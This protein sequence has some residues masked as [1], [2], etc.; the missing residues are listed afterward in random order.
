MFKNFFRFN[1]FLLL[2]S[3]G[4]LTFCFNSPQN[5][6]ERMQTIMISVGNTLSYLSYSP[7]PINEAYSIDVYK[8]YMEI[9][10]PMKRYFLQTDINE[11]EKSKT[12][13]GDYLK[14]GNTSFYNLTVDR[15]YQRMDEIE[16][17][18]LEILDQPI[19][20]N[21]DEEFILEPK[22]KSYPANK[23]EQYSDWKKYIKYNILQ[24][25]Q[26]MIDKEESQK[27][28]KDSVIANH[29]VDTIKYEPISIDEKKIKATEEVKSLMKNMFRRFKKRD[30]NKFFDVYMNAY[31][32]VFDP[33]SNYYSPDDKD[34]FDANFSG[35]FTGIGAQISEKTG[36]LY[37]G[38]LV[39]GAPAWKSK[40]IEEGDEV[41]K[42]KPSPKDE[43]INV[44]GMLVEEVV[45]YIR[46]PK[47]VPV[48]LTLK[49][50]NGATE[51]ITIIRDEIE[52]EDTYAKS[53]V[54]NTDN[55][56]KYGFINLPGFNANFNDPKGRNA[57]DD[58]KNEIIKLK[59]QNIK[60][61]ILDLRY[62][63][64]GSLSEV[65]DIM[66]LFM[67]NG[68]VVQVKDGQ[69]KIQ[70]MKN[71][72]NDPIWTGPLVIMQN[73]LSASASEILSGAIKDYH[74][75]V[76]VGS[77]HSYGKGTVQ[78]FVP[79]K[80]FLNSRNDYG[81]V[82]LTVQKFYRISGKS[83]QLKGVG[84]D[85]VMDN[86]FTHDEI[87]EKYDEFALPWD[88]IPAA[89][90]TP[91][92]KIN[93]EEIEAQSAERIKNNATYQLLLE[94]AKWRKDLSDTK[95]ITL[96]QTKFF[97]LM[98]E[99]KQQVEKFDALTKYNN[100]LNFTLHADE[101]E[102]MKNDEVFSKKRNDWIKNLKRDLYLLEAVHVVQ[103]EE[104]YF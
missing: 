6:N 49:K 60:G 87:G 51:D 59:K 9:L 25:M 73:E 64:G 43:T 30:K 62:N 91:W 47:N 53:I 36:R 81:D 20:M 90:Y 103:D 11:F 85:V 57:S 72:T 55:G 83:T 89:E 5:E 10:D 98:K 102:R 66:G 21:E 35:Q 96:N 2:A 101:Q 31:T 12:Q 56:D 28:K 39:V 82:K 76:I 26:T 40:K 17:M 29:G 74:R 80:K 79:L 7:K 45:K 69:G 24:E 23:D 77:P 68:P 13:L 58:V 86:Y 44:V 15:Y 67:D 71:K 1:K 46:G 70:V 48:V 92:K 63:G 99:R 32:E 104:K 50:K 97:D 54:I 14:K 37:I 38:P 84:S 33:H 75:G 4:T 65:V 8:K 27:K 78:V 42:V 34:D 3:L 93:M 61:I 22:E 41:L 100:G 52:I 95:S 19:D 88:Q 18:S 94:S 16:K